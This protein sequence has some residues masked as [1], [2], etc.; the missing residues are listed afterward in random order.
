MTVGQLGL[1]EGGEAPLE[2]EPAVADEDLR[3]AERLP[4]VVRFG[5]SSWSFP[6][7]AGTVWRGAPTG[8][9]LARA[10]LAAYARHP[11]FRTVGL[12]RGY[13]APLRDAELASYAAQLA[14]APG[15]Q[16][17]SK[18]WDE[19][20][21]AVFPR[22]PRY[23]A[24]A[25]SPNPSFLDAERFLSEV[26]APHA[27]SLPDHTGPFV[28]ELTP[29]PRGALDEVTLAAKVETFL[30]RLPPSGSSGFRW[31]FELRN[32]E[33]FGRRWLDVLRA[34]DASHVFNYWTAMPSLRAQLAA[35]RHAAG[36]LVARLML[37]PMTRYADK[38][39]A[40]A[41]FDR[42]V[43]AQPEMREDLVRLVVAAVEAGAE[44]V[45]VVVNNKAEG[46]APL[47]IRA[48]ADAV[49]RALGGSTSARPAT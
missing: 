16:V 41:P 42:I 25:G 29:M 31:A 1:F 35:G 48:L 40:Y 11:L 5:T 14:G 13:Y 2:V 30:E 45:F 28:F 22:H 18:V 43:E 9:T 49:G 24:R 23:G 26:L 34:H 44:A 46:S 12:D 6:G 20:T 32:P 4:A 33:L 10:G 21:T 27:R 38:R 19:L 8:A 39:A 7:W 15:F 17:V 47:T 36:V 37:P 3:I